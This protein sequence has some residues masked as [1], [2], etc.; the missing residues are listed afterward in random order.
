MLKVF[1][2]RESIEKE[3]FIIS[4]LDLGERNIILVPDQYTLEMEQTLFRQTKKKALI[5][6]EV[7]SMSR[8]GFRLLQ[9]YGG[10]KRSFIDKYGRHML[11]SEI[12]IKEKDNLNVFRGS[13][14]KNSF[15]EMVNNFI[16]EM[17]QFNVAKE[18]FQ[19][20]VNVI[21]NDSYT[22]KKLE[23]LYI[24]F[25]EY[26][27]K[28][29]GK[30]TDSEDKIDLYVN[31][32]KKS[33]EIKESEI[34]VYGFDSFAPKTLLVIMEL[35]KYA[36]NVN[37]VLTYSKEESR[38]K[39]LFILG[40]TIIGNLKTMADSYGIGLVEEEIGKEYIS[41]DKDE[42]IAFLEH[43]LYSLPSYEF[44]GK[45][46][47]IKL[48]KAANIYNEA[49]SAASYVLH[50]IRDENYRLSDIRV[51]CD[52]PN[53]RTPILI[54]VFKE[55]GLE[56]LSD[57][58]KSIIES[59]LVTYIASLLDVVMDGYRTDDVFKM[60]KSGFTDLTHE[61]IV[62]LE[63]YSIKYRI[64]GSMWK[65]PFVKGEFEYGLE[66]LSRLNNL[67]ERAISI[68]S[69]FEKK[70]DQSTYSSFINEIKE[71]IP[72][73]EDNQIYDA[74]I[75][76]I[77]QIG[78]ILGEE[79]FDKDLF[80]KI[81]MIGIKEVEIGVLPPT[82]DGLILGTMERSRI[83]DIKALI[84][85]G[86]NEGILPQDTK[87]EGLFLDDEKELFKENGIELAK[88][89][90][91]KTMEEKM[92]IYRNLIKPKEKLYISY[93]AS[94]EDGKPIRPSIIFNKINEIF[95]DD[96]IENDILNSE[97]LSAII[98]SKIGGKRHLTERLQ[99]TCDGEKL[100]ARWSEALD[101]Y[102]DN[103][104]EELDRIRRGIAFDNS[105][106]YLGR[107]TARILF[108]KNP[109]DDFSLSPSRLEKFSRCPF[110]HLV[111]YGLKPDE[112]RV[113]EPAAREIGDIY[114][115]CLM[116]L[117]TKLT[118][119]KSWLTVRRLDSDKFVE[120]TVLSRM[121]NY[122]EGVF[123]L[124]NAEKYKSK[125]IVENC[126]NVCWAIIEQVRAGEVEDFK[127]E[128][129]FAR[130]GEIKPI[131]LDL[132]GER[133]FIEG[134]ID[135]VD[136]LKDDRVKIIDYK[137]GN[138]SFS[139]LEA[140]RGYRL[141]LMLY[142][143]AAM[144]EK[145]KPAGV[146]YFHIQEPIV[147]LKGKELDEEK[148][149][150]E[151]QKKFKMN[152]VIVDDPEVIKNIAGDFNGYSHIAPVFRYKGGGIKESE[153]VLSDEKFKALQDE[154][155]DKVLETCDRLLDGDVD[156]HPMKTK[157]RSACTYCMYKGICLFDTDFDGNKWNII[158]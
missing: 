128:T 101:W 135:R 8:L 155:N 56:L 25:S 22:K 148:F 68:P 66:E 42:S 15:I 55:Y 99:M 115:E 125:R 40:E 1:Y 48:V 74:V 28:I 10:I 151:I 57:A 34:F 96:G 20:L 72:T 131:E 120:E 26:E 110:S 19:R 146:F 27:K 24:L 18:D 11:L 52:D 141:Q 3:K 133:V 6:T 37:V 23:D 45:T 93:S 150:L 98:N 47:A 95:K 116:E 7:L 81:F 50:L 114:H 153:S 73:L 137:T 106:D 51:I 158:E 103:D 104:K 89:D 76:I 123:N 80:R 39:E 29:E 88:V 118:K 85:V 143:K 82:K 60:L 61:E 21:P 94:D 65:K 134:K 75:E 12:A 64:K 105:N 9:K 54:R 49:E 157:E 17:K 31:N 77:D 70:A 100:D 140:K 14:E 32:I 108:L 107:E 136:Y 112:R 97:D 147:E 119:E 152:G 111:S 58:G 132:G 78:E 127:F 16:S 13:Y 142:L 122:R 102:K 59:P 109:E 126:K 46:E 43:E 5:N 156:I 149:E 62:D 129:T 84:V 117:T 67:R 144:E 145:K 71:I 138:E 36:K 139:S 44:K 90:S 35:A 63:N 91:V 53:L 41:E 92:A 121:E 83:G 87:S 154:V 2:G 30:Y 124:G 33:E 79:K 4:R 130:N 86:A 113:F 69:E 38:D